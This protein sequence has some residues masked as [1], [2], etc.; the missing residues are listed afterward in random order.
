MNN[1][2][3]LGGDY[4]AVDIIDGDLDL[5]IGTS[6]QCELLT[7]MD[8]DSAVLD[9]R[10]GDMELQ[11]ILDGE[12]GAFTKIREGAYPEYTGPTEITPSNETQT[13]ITAQTS[14]LNNITI[15]PIPSNYGLIN[16]NGSTLTV[17]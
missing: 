12:F 16:W 9:V 10:S 6:P 7:I 3:V 15:K 5:L 8:G 4:T 1:T 14:V 2:V 17:S 13:L 11:E